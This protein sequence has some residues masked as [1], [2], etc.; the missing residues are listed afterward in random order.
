MGGAPWL[1]PARG[2]IGPPGPDP[3]A[4]HTNHR[5]VLNLLSPSRLAA[6]W[7]ADPGLLGGSDR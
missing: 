4:G 1:L 5:S 3:G 6:P 2:R 7:I